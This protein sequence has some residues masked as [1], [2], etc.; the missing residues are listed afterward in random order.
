[1]LVKNAKLTSR[2]KKVLFSPTT[3]LTNELINHLNGDEVVHVSPLMFHRPRSVQLYANILTLAC[4]YC[5]ASGEI[6]CPGRF[7]SLNITP[8]VMYVDF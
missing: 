1:M 8:R 6:R 7:T 3:T 4:S 2:V 5:V